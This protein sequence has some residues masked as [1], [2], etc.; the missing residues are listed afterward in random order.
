MRAQKTYKL[1]ITLAQSI[2]GQNTYTA[3]SRMPQGLDIDSMNCELFDMPEFENGE[4]EDDK[5]STIIGNYY[6]GHEPKQAEN[7]YFTRV[8]ANDKLIDNSPTEYEYFS[9]DAENANYT[10]YER[11]YTQCK[12]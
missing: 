9:I 12:S 6:F 3:L 11:L 7:F 4:D 1:T 2:N 8:F 5:D 10:T